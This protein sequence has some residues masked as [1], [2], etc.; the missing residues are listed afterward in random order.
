ME[1]FLLLQGSGPPPW[2]PT[3][4][5]SC[6]G[7]AV[8]WDFT[9]AAT[10]ALNSSHQISVGLHHRPYDF[11]DE[12]R[13]ILRLR[14][15]SLTDQ[16]LPAGRALSSRAEAFVPSSPDTEFVVDSSPDRG[17]DAPKQGV[18]QVLEVEVSAPARQDL[19][20][21]EGGNIQTGLVSPRNLQLVSPQILHLSDTGSS[22]PW[23]CQCDM[24]IPIPLSLEYEMHPW[25]I[26]LQRDLGSFNLH[27]FTSLAL[28]MVAPLRSKRVK[29]I[30]FSDGS[31]WAT[32][33]ESSAFA[34]TVLSTDGENV[35]FD[36]FFS[37][38]VTQAFPFEC[39]SYITSVST[40][41]AGLV[42]AL[43]FCFQLDPDT[44]VEV[45]CDCMPA[46]DNIMK[47]A[48]SEDPFTRIGGHIFEWLSQNRKVEI[49]HTYGHKGNPWNECCDTIA[50]KAKTLPP[51]PL[52]D[53]LVQLLW[54]HDN[55]DWA[56]FRDTLH[57][58]RDAYPVVAENGLHYQWQRQKCDI[59]RLEQA[60]PQKA[61]KYEINMKMA[62]VNVQ[63]AQLSREVLQADQQPNQPV[64]PQALRLQLKEL[65]IHICGCQESPC[66]DEGVVRDGFLVVGTANKEQTLG[67]SLLVNTE[68]PYASGPSGPRTFRRGDIRVLY[69][70]LRVLVVC[71]STACF[72]E[73]VFVVHAPY[74]GHKTIS[75]EGWWAELYELSN[76]WMPTIILGDCN[77]NLS[78]R[79]TFAD[80]DQLPLVGEHHPACVPDEDDVPAVQM[81]NFIAKCGLL[82]ENTFHH[83]EGGH[84]FV[85]KDGERRLDYVLTAPHIHQSVRSLQVDYHFDNYALQ[86]DHFPVV[87]EMEMKVQKTKVLNNSLRL[88]QA[89]LQDLDAREKY[90]A[91]LNNSDLPNWTCDVN[92]HQR[93][94]DE[95]VRS[96]AKACFGSSRVTSI[97]GYLS[98]GTMAMVRLRRYVARA[99]RPDKLTGATS[100]QELLNHEN[101]LI[102]DMSGRCKLQCTVL[103]QAIRDK[104]AQLLDDNAFHN[105]LSAFLISTRRSVRDCIKADRGIFLDKLSE[106]M[107]AYAEKGDHHR[108]WRTLQT[109]LRYGGRRT[110]MAR[111]LLLHKADG[112][113]VTNEQEEAQAIVQHFAAAEDAEILSKK[114]LAERYN[115][116]LDHGPNEVVVDPK[117]VPTISHTASLFSSLKKRK[118]AGQDQIVGE[119]LA[120][121]PRAAARHYHP[122]LAKC[123]LHHQEP[124]E[125]KHGIVFPIPKTSGAATSLEFFRSILLNSIVSKCWHKFIRIELARY[126]GVLLNETQCGG[127][128]RHGPTQLIH[129]VGTF[130]RVVKQKK[131][132][133]VLLFLDLVAAFYSTIRS[134]VL[135]ATGLDDDESYIIS[136]H[137][138]PLTML[139][140]LTFVLAQPAALSQLEGRP[141][142][143]AALIEAHRCT[144]FGTGKC[145]S[146]GRSRRG[147]RP[148]SSLADAIFNLGFSL[149][150]TACRT[151]IA[152][153]DAQLELKVQ[154]ERLL[155]EGL[156]ECELVDGSFVDD[157]VFLLA[158]EP[159]VD[160]VQIAGQAVEIVHRV[161]LTH[162]FAPNYKRSKTAF[163]F[164]I[165]GGNDPLR[166]QLEAVPDMMLTSAE[167]HLEVF[168]TRLYRYLGTPLDQNGDNGVRIA[169]A[170]QKQK[171]A[172]GPIRRMAKYIPSGK[173]G[174]RT[175][176]VDTLCN[177]HLLYSTEV[178][179]SWT[180]SQFRALEAPRVQAY[181][182]LQQRKH[183]EATELYHYD[184]DILV[185]AK[186]V[187]IRYLIR[188]RRLVYFATLLAEAPPQLWFLLDMCRTM[189]GSWLNL[190][191][192]DLAWLD[193]YDT[194]GGPTSLASAW[195]LVR[196]QPKAFRA[197]VERG[198]KRFME[199]Q[200][201]YMRAEALRRNLQRLHVSLQP[202]KCEV[203]FI[204]YEC[205]QL[206]TTVASWRTHLLRHQ[207]IDIAQRYARGSECLCCKS[208]FG[209]RS[210]LIRHLRRPGNRCIFHLMET[211]AM[212]SYEET[213]SLY[214]EDLLRERDMA[215]KGYLRTK[216][217]KHFYS[218]GEGLSVHPYV[219]AV[220]PDVQVLV[221]P[222]PA[223]MTRKKVGLP[224]LVYYIGSST[225]CAER[226][227]KWI[228]AVCP[229]GVR[230]VVYHV[231]DLT[232]L[233][234][235]RPQFSKGEVAMVVMSPELTIWER[236]WNCLVHGGRP[237]RAGDSDAPSSRTKLRDEVYTEN[238]VN[239]MM[240]RV[241][242]CCYMTG[243]PCIMY[244]SCIPLR[245]MISSSTAFND[246]LEYIRC[247]R[248]RLDQGIDGSQFLDAIE[249]VECHS[250]VDLALRDLPHR[251]RVQGHRQVR[252]GVVLQPV[253][254]LLLS[255]VA[256]Q[257]FRW[258]ATLANRA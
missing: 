121:N 179:D 178:W 22:E 119:L 89:K 116:R 49:Q 223:S 79:P 34:C 254:S 86:D 8:G 161:M 10:P 45:V 202:P 111:S 228:T 204:C 99:R 15:G 137:E 170:V 233:D 130:L 109:L 92:E 162:G 188:R 128:A 126:L 24:E 135:P 124:F 197:R 125:W 163:M 225:P 77:A 180:D 189:Q 30:I 209:D 42:W 56:Q 159:E 20:I 40:E 64:R 236:D 155:S 216:V 31:Y 90:V 238:A 168:I 153:L 160:I 258:R 83:H 218:G 222:P 5:S 213:F 12:H 53:R 75:V 107:E 156:E 154:G 145:E 7:D 80:E 115:L 247:P 171:G 48:W 231:V 187:P 113:P 193:Q 227:Q 98:E 203:R 176:T 123:S 243:V 252:T 87:V 158:T 248:L 134:L 41:A 169:A 97:K 63:R 184:E 240:M 206:T 95:L 237:D 71:I 114:E 190:I 226:L 52:P 232:L 210:N 239:M 67:V 88:D 230:Y 217:M 191:V 38:L 69:K 105:A 29:T 100:W 175:A 108:E 76:K 19:G 103:R 195:H 73:T 26:R 44:E 186:R 173:G 250:G 60:Q 244:G 229:R 152:A 164:L 219:P 112:T 58:D 120:I 35:H 94:T 255:R 33:R 205:G 131:M 118:A 106:E 122:I 72:N 144:H 127:R 78:S 50:K 65:G 149:P 136:N 110:R 146:V 68:I 182:Y 9:E 150:L 51:P 141:H 143:L 207:P 196:E 104:R 23:R 74:K 148:G 13:P 2:G 172:L 220:P 200:L 16:R 253:G 251:G 93:I 18:H 55:W 25:H 257:V 166:P 235:I 242:L 133:S 201:D 59:T 81:R 14:G 11:L 165:S 28:T 46:I 32:E 39:A 47:R 234:K 101:D 151:Q 66:A 249:M 6:G 221:D 102:W 147:S 211:E 85:G 198:W 241:F 194:Q 199:Y 3:K 4:N 27:E 208:R 61:V 62:T 43:L 84:T 17:D 183:H 117:L 214:H 57:R 36:G 245:R 215:S 140:L 138:L 37:G 82:V 21:I 181:R 246:F 139:P 192:D 96:A 212:M 167:L 1:P 256:A 70:S 224:M 157:A 54:H 185:E 91:I 142:L 132:N 177:V 129:T 174:S